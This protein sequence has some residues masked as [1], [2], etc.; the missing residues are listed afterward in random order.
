MIMKYVLLFNLLWATM[1]QGQSDYQAACNRLKTIAFDRP[2]Q[3]DQIE[4]QLARIAKILPTI[5]E[6]ALQRCS[7]ADTLWTAVWRDRR[8]FANAGGNGS[9]DTTTYLRFLAGKIDSLQLNATFRLQSA[10]NLQDS[11]HLVL[12]SIAIKDAKKED[13]EYSNFQFYYFTGAEM[14]FLKGNRE[15][16]R[17]QY[18]RI[19]DAPNTT[20][21]LRDRILLTFFNSDASIETA[22][23]DRIV[24]YQ[25]SKLFYRMLGILRTSGTN[26][27]AIF[28]LDMLKNT[29]CSTQEKD[30]ILQA[31][32]G[33]KK[34]KQL[35]NKTQREFEQYL[36]ESK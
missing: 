23:L 35:T 36:A 29:A 12:Q 6:D 7:C 28:L 26:K 8:H 21:M 5:N 32:H 10:T 17:D 22:I 4:E 3:L 11:L 2:F 31:I 25:K 34:R 15:R 19:F 18:L 14:A 24:D 33:I 13:P 1:L 30:S 27:S 9:L 20:D 16:L